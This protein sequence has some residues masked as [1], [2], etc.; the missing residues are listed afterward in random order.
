MMSFSTMTSFVN[1]PGFPSAFDQGYTCSY[2]DCR[3]SLDIHVTCMRLYMCY[4]MMSGKMNECCFHLIVLCQHSCDTV[5]CIEM[6]SDD[7]PRQH[8]NLTTPIFL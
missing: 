5:Y 6:M 8:N 3:E 7:K 2:V 4:F 1:Q